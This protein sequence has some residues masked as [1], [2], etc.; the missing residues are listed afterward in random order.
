[1]RLHTNSNTTHVRVICVCVHTCACTHTHTH[2]HTHHTTHTHYVNQAVIVLNSVKVQIS[3]W[4]QKHS[5]DKAGETDARTHPKI[6]IYILHKLL[7]PVDLD[8]PLPLPQHCLEVGLSSVVTDS[9]LSYHRQATVRSKETR[10][11]PITLPVKCRSH[12][13]TGILG[14]RKSV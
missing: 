6:C 5:A 12:E 13:L 9:K 7:P 8:Y 14:T 2:R 3:R 4:R 11:R 1:M 10:N